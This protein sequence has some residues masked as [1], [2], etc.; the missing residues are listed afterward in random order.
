MCNTPIIVGS[1]FGSIALT[2]I[3]CIAFAY[4]NNKRRDKFLASLSSAERAKYLE[5]ELAQ[6]KIR[7]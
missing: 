6:S 3:I 4:L 5:N 7:D 2:F 1:I